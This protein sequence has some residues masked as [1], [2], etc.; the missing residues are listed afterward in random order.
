MDI[1]I[2]T[3]SVTPV[4]RQIADAIRVGL[5]EGTL[6]PGDTLPPIRQIALDLGVN[7]NTVA[8]AY[9]ILAAEGWL[10][11][12]RRRGATVVSRERPTQTAR[13]QD[14]DSFQR[15]LREMVAKAR[16]AGVPP[17]WIASVLREGAEEVES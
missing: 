9:R 8:H 2:D 1:E 11:L 7:F 5:V 4:Y 15:R 13:S 16:S 6:S 3:A 12:R 17:Q 10:E 14:K